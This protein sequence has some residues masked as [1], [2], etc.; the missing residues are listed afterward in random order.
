LGADIIATVDDDNIPY[1]SWG[2]N[3][4]LGKETEV[5]LYEP[6]GEFFDPLS[7]TNTKDLW[8]RGYPIEDLHTKN[9]VEYKGKVKKK[10]DIQADLWDGDPD[11]DAI[12]RLSKMPC[13]KYQTINPYTSTKLSPFNSQNTFLTRAAIKKY[14]VLPFV[15]RMD[16]I[17]GGYILQQEGFS[18]VYNT[19]TVYQERNPQDLIKN[20][21]NEL[22]GYRFTKKLLKKELKL[23]DIS[24]DSNNCYSL[25]KTYFND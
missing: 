5:D 3:L 18:V 12:C 7:V 23:S 24:I 17:W 25:Y 13:V 1:E 22:I 16:D 10:F 9:S 19:S 6:S 8:H 14:M 15:G 2:E 4:L 11:I 20:L 21:E